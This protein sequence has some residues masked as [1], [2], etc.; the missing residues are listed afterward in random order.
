MRRPFLIALIAVGAAVG[1]FA[2]DGIP[3]GNAVFYPSVEAVYTHTDNLFLQDP[4]MNS[5]N[6]DYGNVSDSFWGDQAHPR[7][8]V[9]LQGEL[10]PAG[11]RLPV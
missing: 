11:P 9:P 2:G 6:G 8:R 3:I 4:N 10:H 1:V 7:V 5:I